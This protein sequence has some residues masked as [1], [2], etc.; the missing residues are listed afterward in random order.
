MGSNLQPYFDEIQST[1]DSLPEGSCQRQDYLNHIR[2]LARWSQEPADYPEVIQVEFP[3]TT[4]IA[5]AVCHSECGAREF[6]V[7]GSTQ[8]CQRCGG[9]MFRTEEQEYRMQS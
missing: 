7:D 9:T 6:I 5:F 2:S 3:E 1:L 8:R 4:H